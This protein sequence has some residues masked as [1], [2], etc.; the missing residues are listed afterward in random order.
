MSPYYAKL[1]K[2]IDVGDLKEVALWGLVDE[3]V[4][5]AGISERTT[6]T[7][8]RE[9]PFLDAELRRRIRKWGALALIVCFVALVVAFVAVLLY[10]TFYGTPEAQKVAFGA[11]GA[12]L[13]LLWSEIRK[14]NE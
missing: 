2:T 5:A 6:E 11:L 8:R 3:T 12:V 1:S 7:S 13:G 9:V 10:T 4:P 14:L